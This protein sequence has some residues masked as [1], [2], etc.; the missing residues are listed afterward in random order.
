MLVHNIDNNKPLVKAPH[1]E[2][3]VER[4]EIEQ[5]DPK[6]RKDDARVFLEFWGTISKPKSVVGRQ[7]ISPRFSKPLTRNKTM[8]KK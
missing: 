8:K 2:T 3:R 4:K 5:N 7:K 1:I 6:N